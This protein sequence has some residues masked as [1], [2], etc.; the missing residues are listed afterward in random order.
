MIL[1]IKTPEVSKEIKYRKLRNGELEEGKPRSKEV[2][3]R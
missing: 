2:N 3:Y 1:K